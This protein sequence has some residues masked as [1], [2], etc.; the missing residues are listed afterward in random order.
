M[1]RAYRM[2][3]KFKLRTVVI[4]GTIRMRWDNLSFVR[5]KRSGIGREKVMDTMMEMTEPK[6]MIFKG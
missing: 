4:H 3:R 5:V 6:L 1:K 2:A